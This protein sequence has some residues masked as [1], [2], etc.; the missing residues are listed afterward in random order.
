MLE[1]FRRLHSGGQ[2]IMMVTHDDTV[3]ESASR[4]VRMRDGRI[5]GDTSDVAATVVG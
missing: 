5:E 3:A 1:L 2:T 4:I